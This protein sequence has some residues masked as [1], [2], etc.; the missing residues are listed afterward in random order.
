MNKEFG[1]SDK[2]WMVHH[3]P[4]VNKDLLDRL[5]AMNC[6]VEMGAFRW[7]T[8]NNANVAGPPFRT[9]VDHGI[10]VGIH[11]DGVHIAPLNPWS[12]IQYAVTGLNSFGTQVNPNQHLTRQEAI[13]LFT[14]NNAWFLKMEDRIGSLEIGKYGDLAVLDRD[15]FSI[16]ENDIRNIRSTMTIV[17]GKIV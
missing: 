9:I 3:V 6:G 13:R 14:R 11:G 12:H 5:K 8:S 10:T 2:R 4:E 7:V 16:P 15:Y 17:G 1:I